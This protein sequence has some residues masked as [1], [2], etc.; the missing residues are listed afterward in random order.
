[1]SDFD[2]FFKKKLD[3]EGQFPRRDKNW[4]A[5]S[6]RLDAFHAGLQEHGTAIQTSLRYWQAAASLA[7]VATGWL[8]WKVVTVRSENAEL[9]QEM[10][11]LQEQNKAH[12]SEI[13]TLKSLSQPPS[14]QESPKLFFEER[15]NYSNS[16]NISAY[17]NNLLSNNATISGANILRT[18]TYEEKTPS[19]EQVV[20]ADSAQTQTADLA[21]IQKWPNLEMLPSDSLEE[22]VSQSKTTPKMPSLPKENVAAA[23]Q[24][25]EPVR[26]PSRF[27]AGIQFLTGFPQPSEEGISPLMGPG[28]T[29]EYNLWRDIWLTASADWLRFDVSTPKYC[30]KFH[31]SH[32]PPPPPHIGPPWYKEKLVNVKSTQSQQQFGL[33]MRYALPVRFWVRPS[34]R[35]AYTWARVSPELLTLKYQKPDWPG[36]PPG[37]PPPTYKVQ[38]SETQIV[39]DTWR[40]GIGFERE[41]PHLVFGLWADYSKSFAA[42]DPSFDMLLLR[43]GIQYRM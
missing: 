41:T 22:V 12:E 21:K 2:K 17:R 36:G 26:A 35:A 29:A 34:I 9:R 43:A 18:K 28:L 4:R 30:P 1:M 7:L 40:F 42:N 13:V 32:D 33:G 23:P 5:L 39:G 10:A 19:G 14:E 11:V 27:R 16:K 31:P 24:L 20:T 3:E 15:E 25:I 6:K 38:E 37:P 8:T